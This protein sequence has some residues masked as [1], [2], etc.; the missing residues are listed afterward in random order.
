MRW[1]ALVAALVAFAPRTAAFDPTDQYE[2]RDMRGFAILVNLEVHKH[3]DE[4]K[5]WAG[6]EVF[7]PPNVSASG[8]AA[9]RFQPPAWNELRGLTPEERR[10]V[11]EYFKKINAERP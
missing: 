5:A 4:A 9:T 7:T 1:L 3:A 2:K 8:K 10:L 11:L 6:S